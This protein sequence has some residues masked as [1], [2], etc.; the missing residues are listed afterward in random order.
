[1]VRHGRV[2]EP[3]KG[4]GALQAQIGACKTFGGCTLNVRLHWLLAFALLTFAAGCRDNGRD[5]YLALTGKVFI[6]NYR[7]ATATYVVTFGMLRPIPEGS[8]A[9]AEFD[10]P[11][12]GAPL[13]VEQKVWPKTGKVA[14][15]SPPLTCVKKAR[16][17]GFSVSLLG[18][19]GAVL[20]VI[21]STLTSTL[22]QTILPDRPLVVGPVYTPNPE[23]AGHPDGKLLGNIKSP[24]P[25]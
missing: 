15:E 9:V 18:P 7:V 5:E 8:T 25:N 17:Y 4:Q 1:M 3:L 13:R 21:A 19:D 10:N 16:P 20:Q 24:C 22:D 6:F 23:L 11:G 12:G 14:V 2:R